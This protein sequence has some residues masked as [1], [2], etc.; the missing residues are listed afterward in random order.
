MDKF[1]PALDGAEVKK[2]HGFAADDDLGQIRFG[3]PVEQKLLPKDLLEDPSKKSSAELL[4][5]T[6][7][8]MVPVLS[9]DKLACL[10]SVRRDV[11][12]QWTEDRL[13][14][15]ELARALDAV[16]RAWPADKGYR[17][18]LV[19]APSLQRFFVQVPQ[20]APENL[21]PLDIHAPASGV[22]DTWKT[23]KPAATT[24][25]SLRK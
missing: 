4:K 21:T 22:P 1:A 15:V 18:V 14:M 25:D 19:V 24:I 13:G 20:Q 17:P 6:G 5:D 2:T 11:A 8:W 16:C 12:G 10:V 7:V 9:R 23:L 3:T